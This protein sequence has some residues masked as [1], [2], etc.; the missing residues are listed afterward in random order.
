MERMIYKRQDKSSSFGSRPVAMAFNYFQFEFYCTL[1][2]NLCWSEAHVMLVTFSSATSTFQ[3][4]YPSIIMIY[5]YKLCT[6]ILLAPCKLGVYILL[7]ISISSLLFYWPLVNLFINGAANKCPKIPQV[8]PLVTLLRFSSVREKEKGLK[9]QF[10]CLHAIGIS[11]YIDIILQ[12]Q[13]VGM[14]ENEFRRWCQISR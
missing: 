12:I 8:F 9:S 2:L 4:I 3:F 13:T 1:F 6:I 14:C 7:F 11:L 10:H 5:I